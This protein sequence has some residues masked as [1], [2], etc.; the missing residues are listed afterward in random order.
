MSDA[1]TFSV[2][3]GKVIDIGRKSTD[4]NEINGQYM[5]LIKLTPN[6]WSSISKILEKIPREE[7]NKLD[8]TSLLLKLI[9]SGITVDGIGVRGGWVEVDKS[10]DIQNYEICIEKAS[11]KG[12]RWSHDW[13]GS[14]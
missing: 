9:S 13:M 14:K 3:N 8:I 1:E 11:K 12:G 10:T 6:G 2:K 4:L 7:K 5:G